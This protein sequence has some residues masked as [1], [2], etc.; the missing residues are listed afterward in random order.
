[1]YFYVD[2]SGHT[3]LNIFDT[4]QPLLYYGVLSSKTNVDVLAEPTLI[5]LRQSLGVP[6]LHAA[7]IGNAGLSKIIGTIDRLQKKLDLRFDFYTVAK[8]DHAL[9]CFF[10]QVFDNGV[11]PAITWSGYWTPLR[12]MLLLKVA[13]LFDEDT[14]KKAWD[15]RI[16]LDDKKAEQ[17]LVDVCRII[18]SRIDELPDQ[19][20]RT[21]IGDSLQWAETNPSKI[22][23]NVSGKKDRLS[24]SPNIIGFQT[25]MH[26]IMS[27]LKLSNTKAS[28]IIVDQQ[29]QFN[30]A[31]KTLSEYFVSMKNIPW[32]TGPGLPVMDLKHMPEVPISFLSSN[33]S[34][35]LELVDIYLW[36][37]KRYIEKKDLS[38]ETYPFIRRQ[39]PRVRIDEVSINAIASRW[40]KVFEEMPEPT[41]EQL[42]K[43]RAML[44]LDESRR[45]EAMRNVEGYN[46]VPLEA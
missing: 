32:I 17:G 19:R 10:D 5:N 35:G 18:R 15:A 3:G 30:K 38:V 23:Y 16:E 9:I 44:E 36:I 11:N 34:A 42:A 46:G 37:F 26:G 1:M 4:S 25:V 7:E 29:S 33:N 40:G 24:I 28:S 12:Y 8:A 21:L 20:S 13:Y 22:Q 41:A 45:L 27:R 39:S 6:R 2:E 31:Q 43:A 14:L